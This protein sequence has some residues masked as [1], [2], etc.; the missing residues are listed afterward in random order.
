MTATKALLREAGFA[1]L[2]VDAIA[3][4]SGV[5]K[6]TV[7]RWW[8]NRADVAMEA[9][10]EERDPVGWFV[11]DGPA[12]DSLR[13]QLHIATEFLG[14]P[15]GTV[16]AG[17]L[18]DAQH[19]PQ[20]AGAFRQRFLQ[21]LVQL[22]RQLLAVAAAEGDIRP[23]VD[24]DTVMDLLTGPLYFRLLVTGAPFSASAT[25]ALIDAALRGLRPTAG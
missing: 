17:L 25:E 2:T 20:L 24:S 4:R 14:G 22:T 13:R 9:L 7:Y 23:D 16:V 3:E 5:G 11:D 19:D 18:G 6:A 15:D 21:P 10:L 1:R 8:S 12:I